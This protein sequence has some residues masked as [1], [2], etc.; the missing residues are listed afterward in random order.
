M[1]AC[2][3]ELRRLVRACARY[4]VGGNLVRALVG[5]RQ[6]CA[7]AFRAL[8]PFHRA[9]GTSWCAPLQPV[10]G[11]RCPCLSPTPAP[12]C[13]R[14][15]SRPCHPAPPPK[16][17]APPPAFPAHQVEPGDVLL[18]RWTGAVIG[19]AAFGEGRPQRH[20]VGVLD[21]K[22]QG[23]GAHVRPRWLLRPRAAAPLCSE[24]TLL[25]P[26][27]CPK[28]GPLR[29]QRKA[30]DR[31]VPV[32]KTCFGTYHVAANYSDSTQQ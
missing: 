29:A 23:V 31:A 24:S 18:R 5:R 30:P 9:P 15:R 3:G 12:L 25:T 32:S 28:C 22:R 19:L 17:N 27:A 8:A 21:S 7:R 1:S 4:S 11:R 26:A 14:Q 10:K 20:H 6:R 16:L 2:V 13:R